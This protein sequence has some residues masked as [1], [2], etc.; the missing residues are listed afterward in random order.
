MTRIF[1]ESARHADESQ[2]PLKTR[3][4]RVKPAMTSKICEN[5]ENLRHLRA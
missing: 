2:H 4:L 5:P 3:G 1:T